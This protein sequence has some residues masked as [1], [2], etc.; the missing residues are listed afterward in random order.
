MMVTMTSCLIASSGSCDL[1]FR[2][3]DVTDSYTRCLRV[4]QCLKLKKISRHHIKPEHTSKILGKVWV[5][6]QAVASKLHTL[7]SHRN[8]DVIESLGGK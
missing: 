1:T 4:K 5:V 8:M 6:H 7:Q 2:K 3:S